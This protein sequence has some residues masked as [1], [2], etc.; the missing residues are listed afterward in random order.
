MLQAR[1]ETALVVRKVRA[2]P[3]SVWQLVSPLIFRES[4]DAAPLEVPAGTLTDFA[5]VPRLPLAFLLAGDK[6]HAAAV[7]H[8][9]LYTVKKTTRAEADRLFALAIRAEGHSGAL[10]RLMHLAVRAG[11]ARS[12]ES[13]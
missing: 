12:W 7:L 10:A 4:D 9:W 13:P 11:G 6:A 1:F 2:V 3:G 8:D 5:S